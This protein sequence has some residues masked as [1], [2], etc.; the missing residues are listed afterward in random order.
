MG[1]ISGCPYLRDWFSIET[2]GVV[3][4]GIMESVSDVPNSG[5]S[6]SCNDISYT[7]VLLAGF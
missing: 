2:N 1:P 5:V 6:N 7:C 3:S 4:M